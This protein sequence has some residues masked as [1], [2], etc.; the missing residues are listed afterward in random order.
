VAN[1]ER[2]GTREGI[3]PFL[4]ELPAEVKTVQAEVVLLE[5]ISAEFM[6]QIP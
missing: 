4:V 5:S 1:P 3:Q 2:Q 6:V